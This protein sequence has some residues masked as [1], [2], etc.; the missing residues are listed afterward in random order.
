MKRAE[1]FHPRVFDDVD[2]ARGYYENNKES[3]AQTG[4]RLGKLLTR[5]D[6]RKGHLVDM[7]CGFGGV[8]AEIAILHPKIRVTGIDLAEPL[9]EIA[10]DLADRKTVED[11]VSFAKGDVQHVDLPDDS[12]D[13]VVSSYMLHIVEDPLRMLAEIERIAKPGATILITDLRRIW[14]AWFEKKLRTAFSTQE[15][16][17][18]IVRSVLRKGVFATGPFWWDYIVEGR[19]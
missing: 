14:V 11:R 19:R 2:W 18:L 4:R 12:A 8:A 1:L 7:G 10:E 9:L 6:V 13:I 17:E 16:R 3:I 15:A 5:L